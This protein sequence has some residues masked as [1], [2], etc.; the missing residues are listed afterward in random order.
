MYDVLFWTL[1]TANIVVAIYLSL[2]SYMHAQPWRLLALGFFSWILMFWFQ[3]SIETIVKLVGEGK[4]N[5]LRSGVALLATTVS[6]M[7]GAVF[8]TAI[9]NRAKLLNKKEVERL[10]ARMSHAEERYQKPAEEIYAKLTNQD[11]PLEREEFLR[12][13]SKRVELLA[14]YH[15]EMSELKDE[16]RK[17]NP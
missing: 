8:G 5:G 14:D 1:L 6:A 11:V 7:V 3:N 13:H 2:N 9:T 17:L 12:L 4:A 10:M 16:L 15:C